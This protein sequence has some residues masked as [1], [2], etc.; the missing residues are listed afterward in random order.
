MKPVRMR[1]PI[2]AVSPVRSVYDPI[3]P[4]RPLLFTDAATGKI[5]GCYKMCVR[6][7]IWYLHPTM[8]A[9]CGRAL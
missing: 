4:A 7:G 8:P 2:K 1:L 3:A 9:P 5:T 6:T